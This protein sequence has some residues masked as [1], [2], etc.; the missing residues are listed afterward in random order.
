MMPFI[1]SST[2]SSESETLNTSQLKN[3]ITS[4]PVFAWASATPVICS[5]WPEL[6][7]KSAMTS[8]LFF[9]AQALTC[10]CMT[11]LA[12]GTQWSQKPIDTFPAAPAV[13]M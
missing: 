13:R 2:G 1:R 3:V 11:S 7:M 4:W 12:P 9:S 10:F 6:A 8:T 5:F